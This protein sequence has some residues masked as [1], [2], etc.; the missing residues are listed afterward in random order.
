MSLESAHAHARD[1]LVRHSFRPQ[2]CLKIVPRNSTQCNMMPTTFACLESNCIG[3]VWDAR[4]IS[5]S[6]ICFGRAASRA[7]LLFQPQDCTATRA[8]APKILA[9]MVWR[10]AARL[11]SWSKPLDLNVHVTLNDEPR[12]SFAHY[13]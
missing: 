11:S 7:L 4:D 3:A 1:I 9:T 2:N 10:R 6:G 13:I 8:D 12:I 5:S